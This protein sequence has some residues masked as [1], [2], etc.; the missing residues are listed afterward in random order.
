MK[1]NQY[2]PIVVSDDYQNVNADG[3]AET[4]VSQISVGFT[5]H[6]QTKG[7]VLSV[8][9]QSETEIEIPLHQLIDLTI[10]FCQT[11]LYFQDAYRFPNYYDPEKMQIARIG[12]QGDAMTVAIDKSNSMLDHDIKDFAD[13]L[14]KEDERIS[15]RLFVLSRILKEACYDS[16]Y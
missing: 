15:E 11:K 2:C 5:R 16:K 10:L 8:R 3:T 1:H 4:E 14:S 7:N 9:I 12:L 6:E 13:Q